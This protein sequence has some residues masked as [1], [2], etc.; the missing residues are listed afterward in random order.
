MSLRELGG[1]CAA[2]FTACSASIVLAMDF[3]QSAKLSRRY[4]AS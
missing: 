2:I 1:Q 3:S 4:L